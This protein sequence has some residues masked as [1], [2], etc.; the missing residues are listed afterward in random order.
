MPSHPLS[1]H[2]PP[3]FVRW[4]RSFDSPSLFVVV[5]LRFASL[6]LSRFALALRARVH[7]A[8]APFPFPFSMLSVR[9]H[10]LAHLRVGWAPTQELQSLHA[11]QSPRA[12]QPASPAALPAAQPGITAS[13]HFQRPYGSRRNLASAFSAR[14]KRRLRLLSACASAEPLRPSSMRCCPRRRSARA[15]RS[16]RA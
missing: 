5:A 15:S 2:L 13:S 9:P 1:P 7:G 14:L 10:A 12:P 6:A 3:V 16:V 4:F 11:F 8:A